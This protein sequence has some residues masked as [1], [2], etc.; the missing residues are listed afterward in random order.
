MA[1]SLVSTGIQFPD[2]TIQTTA[3]TASSPPG[4]VLINAGTIPSGTSSADITSGFS[5]AYGGY[6]VS[7]DGAMNT[8]NR[9]MLR[10]ICDGSVVTESVSVYL[11]PG[12]YFTPSFSTGSYNGTDGININPGGGTTWGFRALVNIYGTTTSGKL[13]AVYYSHCISDGG[14]DTGNTGIKAN[15]LAFTTFNGVNI[16]GTGGQS[17]VGTLTYKIW[18]WKNS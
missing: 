9:T 5:S 15:Q 3:A 1:V 7:I 8:Q 13:R 18:G 16:F 17:T 10:Y 6:T 4:L 12:I 14:T 11:G 2:S